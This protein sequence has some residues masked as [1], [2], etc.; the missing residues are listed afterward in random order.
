MTKES[1]VRTAAMALRHDLC[2]HCLGR[3][4]ARSGYGL[5]NEERGSSIRTVIALEMES[6]D[7]FFEPEETNYLSKCIPVHPVKEE[8]RE[9]PLPDKENQ[10]HWNKPM[11]P[12]F[13][14]IRT[15]VDDESGKCWLCDN[16]FDRVKE[17]A[18]FVYERSSE[19]DFNSYVI[20][21]RIDPQTVNREQELWQEC[22]PSSPEPLKEELNREVGKIFSTLR[23]E[24]IFDRSDP[25]VAFIVDPL[26]KTLSM[27]IKP[28]FIFGRYRK[29]ERGI[30]QTRWP[31]RK[32]R[33][34]GC[35]KCDGTGRMYKNSIEELIGE[36]PKTMLEGS[37]YKLHG[38]GREDVDVL[39]L[40]D[41]R[42]FII[43]ITKPRMRSLDLEVMKNRVNSSTDGKVEVHGLRMS[44]RKE[45][46][47]I[48]DGTSRKSYSAKISFIDELDEETL[49][50]NISLLAQSPIKQ[51]TPSRVSHRRADKVRTRCVHQ[52]SL[53][54][55]SKGKAVI[56]MTTD[57][58][59]YIKE[60][61]N[62]DDGRTIPS[63]SS[64]LGMELKVESLDVTGVL[65]EDEGQ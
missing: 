16:I 39:S 51:R 57:G 8:I 65:Y 64:L 28:V 63:L 53:K 12:S 25:D 15:S 32:C 7:G 34:K 19:L 46:P 42:P 13:N 17:L 59:L 43:E 30:P 4:F 1:I 31:C 14:R 22:D 3:L 48:K 47:E 11:T 6:R 35:D 24:K 9:D 18:E 26:Y 36:H 27:Q 52:A 44:T 37:D 23:P 33:G 58:G 21:C 56:D 45:V 55:F 10:D 2:D 40:G 62:G 5:T 50:Y 54:A 20:G 38:M 49:K 60:L 61:L 41:G 29:L